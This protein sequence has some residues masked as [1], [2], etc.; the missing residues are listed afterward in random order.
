MMFFQYTP[1]E[2]NEKISDVKNWFDRIQKYKEEIIR[3]ESELQVIMQ[4]NVSIRELIL[5]KQELNAIIL[6][7][8]TAI[9][10][11]EDMGVFIKSVDQGLI[12]FP[13][14][15]FDEEVWLCWKYGEDRIKFW[16]GKDEGFG[17]RKPLE[18][19]GVIEP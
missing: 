17:G 6:N 14:I 10:N 7:Y 4:N 16:H 5:K 11:I 2:A 12:D 19:T 9:K 15:K 1:T 3:I 13:S 18:S 8:Y